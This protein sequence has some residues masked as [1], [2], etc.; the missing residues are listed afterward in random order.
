V[1]LFV[2]LP[3]PPSPRY[4]ELA[5]EVARAAPGAR[6]VPDGTWH[7]TARFL[8][9]VLDAAPLIRALEVACNGR[10]ALPCVVEGLGTFPDKFPPHKH[11]RVAWAGVRAAGIEALAHAIE[12]AT[13]GFGD[14]PEKR[15]FVAHVTLARLSNAADLRALVDR[16]RGT[17]LAQGRIDRVVLFR[18]RTGPGGSAYEPLHTVR[19]A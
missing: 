13:A 8:G 19:L 15:R 4:A 7:V 10:P 2:G 5:A 6:V 18:S 12:Q 1:R 16:H 17:L 9:E 11:A 3:V 14:P